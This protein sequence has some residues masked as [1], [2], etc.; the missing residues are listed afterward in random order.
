MIPDE[1]NEFPVLNIEDKQEALEKSNVLVDKIICSDKEIEK[2]NDNITRMLDK[3]KETKAKKVGIWSGKIVAIEALQEA[4]VSQANNIE[5]LWDYQKKS[6]EQ[7]DS[8]A[9]NMRKLFVLG[10]GNAAYTRAIIEQIKTRSHGN[11]SES[12]RKQLLD[13][14]RDLEKQADINDRFDR[15]KA[16]TIAYRKEAEERVSKLEA[17]LN[18]VRT[19]IREDMDSFKRESKFAN[20]SALK[21]I[22]SK[23][24]YWRIA[25]IASVILSATAICLTLI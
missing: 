22:E 18:H 10:V 3:A 17:S 11:L 19:T 2:S 21:K 1:L 5:M 14:I 8:M 7:M 12:A 6:F 24:F 20:D 15:L 13:V 4:A 9:S 16:S 23:Q 25:T